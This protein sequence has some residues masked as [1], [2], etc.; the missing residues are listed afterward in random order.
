[1]KYILDTNVMSEIMKAPPDPYVARWMEAIVDQDLAVSAAA[2]M[3][4]RRGVEM[5]PIGRRRTHLDDWLSREVPI[6]FS[7]RILAMDEH[8]AD[9]CGRLLGKHRLG[10]EVKKLMDFWMAALALQHDLTVVTRNVRD[11][12]ETGARLVNPWDE[13]SL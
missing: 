7:G 3:E 9:L 6:R 4:V 13:V 1:M 10:L 8:T 12:R 11:F 2:I 5:M